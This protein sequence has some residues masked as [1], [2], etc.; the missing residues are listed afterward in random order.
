MGKNKIIKDA[1]ALFVITL[2]SGLCLG[3]VYNIT[4][5]PIALAEEQA[6][7]ESYQTVFP[8][9][10]SFQNNGDIDTAR[11]SWTADGAE[12]TEVLEAVDS[13]GTVLGYVVSVTATEGYGGDI[14]L[15]LG[16]AQDGT[17]TGLEV[18]SMSE[19]AGLGAKC[20]TQE[21]KSQFAG[22]QKDQVVMNEDFD[23]ISSATVTSSAIEKGVN[24]ALGFVSEI[25]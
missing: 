25:R 16:V 20:T 5:D 17:I 18:L 12:V 21:F 10:A 19:T 13:A 3:F 7:Q 23:Q 4:K 8:E 22:I 24:G 14:S 9:A 11:A 15:S 2:V 1:I 6:K